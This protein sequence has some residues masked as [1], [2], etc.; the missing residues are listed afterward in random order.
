[1]VP[2]TEFT[3]EIQ[4]LIERKDEIDAE[5][6]IVHTFNLLQ[7]RWSFEKSKEHKQEDTKKYINYL[8][9][10]HLDTKSKRENFYE[11]ELLKTYKER[12]FFLENQASSMTQI[13]DKLTS[14]LTLKTFQSPQNGY[15]QQKI[16]EYSHEYSPIPDAPCFETPTKDFIDHQTERKGMN[17]I[18]DQLSNVRKQTHQKY[19]LKKKN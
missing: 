15:S 1:M 3:D 8:I 14:N 9:R 19:I 13:I 12:I 10:Q 18:E 4:I 2:I 11:H 16:S 6:Y 17:S 7:E 5:E